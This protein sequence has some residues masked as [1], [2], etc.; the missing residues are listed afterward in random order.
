[1]CR[2]AM[3]KP[4]RPDP[5]LTDECYAAANL[6]DRGLI[7]F[8][9]CAHAGLVNRFLTRARRFPMSLFR[10]GGRSR[11]CSTRSEKRWSSFRG[12]QP[13]Q[14]MMQSRPWRLLLLVP[15]PPQ[16]RVALGAM[17]LAL[18]PFG[19]APVDHT[20]YAAVALLACHYHHQ[21]I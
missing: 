9:S 20:K 10:V 3:G 14:L 2:D 8:S 18:P 17:L 6:R 5:L 13:V 1:M 19:S 16:H 7:V 4:W 12:R 15:E 21:R 11:P